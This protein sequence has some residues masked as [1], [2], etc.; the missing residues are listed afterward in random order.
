MPGV[1]RPG[2]EEA[3]ELLEQA[4]EAGH[5]GVMVKSLDAPY[6]AGRRGRAWQKVKPVH[7]LDLVVI[8]AEWGYGR[9]TGTLSNIHL[10]ARDPDG[11]ERSWWAR[12]S[13]A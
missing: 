7:T 11:G 1:L 12:R 6:A 2:A 3:A 8:G 10:G 9:R 13:R 4:L 5:E